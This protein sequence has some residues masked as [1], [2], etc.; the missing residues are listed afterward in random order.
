VIAQT[1]VQI[2]S[3]VPVNIGTIQH[4]RPVHLVIIAR[5]VALHIVVPNLLVIQARNQ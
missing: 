5:V 2:I 3:A 1:W 4:A